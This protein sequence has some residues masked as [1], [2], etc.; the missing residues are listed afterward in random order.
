MQDP[1][2]GSPQGGGAGGEPKQGNDGNQP[3]DNKPADKGASGGNDENVVTRETLQGAQNALKRT[4]LD[5]IK[6]TS[7]ALKDEL[8]TL[9][10]EKLSALKP[11]DPDSGDDKKRGKDKLDPEVAKILR[12]HKDLQA[13]FE[14]TQKELQTQID[15]NKQREFRS[16]VVAELQKAGC[17][18]PDAAFRIISDDLQVDENDPG[19]IFHVQKDDWGNVHDV[20]LE[21][22]ITRVA[23]NE[24]IPELFPA[25]SGG[26]S[27]AGGD[28]GG[29]KGYLFT[30]EQI[31]DPEFYHKN[32]EEIAQALQAGRVKG[33]PP[34]G[35]AGR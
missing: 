1:D 4:L 22:Y 29:G 26:G 20:G 15:Q 35:E 27:P 19:R 33:V 13:K 23:R 28:S 17:K 24:I 8:S 10:D 9:F 11:P 3:G 21:E 2:A 6:N 18:R 34:P 5:Q 12:E 7:S 30:K 32:H 14:Q 25:N 16:R 31:S